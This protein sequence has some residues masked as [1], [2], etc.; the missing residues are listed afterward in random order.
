MYEYKP[1][2][3]KNTIRVLDLRQ[4]RDYGSLHGELR[5]VRLSPENALQPMD[6]DAPADNKPPRY[7]ALSYVWGEPTFSRSLDC[8][9]GKISLTSNLETALTALS[10][11]DR[12]RAIWVDAICIDQRN[13]AERGHQV[14]LMGQIFANAERVLIWLGPD[15]GGIARDT[16]KAIRSLARRPIRASDAQDLERV[17][18]EVT[19]LEW[20]YRLWVVQELVLAQEA[21]VLWGQEQLDFSWIQFVLLQSQAAVVM[22]FKWIAFKNQFSQFDILDALDWFRPLRCAD[23]RDRVYAI[24]G[25]PYGRG[26]ALTARVGDI[27]PDYA[28]SVEQLFYEIACICVECGQIATLLSQVHHT[29]DFGQ[30][31][32]LQ[33]PSW[34]PD[35]T[36]P[37]QHY[38]PRQKLCKDVTRW[39]RAQ[40][41]IYQSSRSLTLTGVLVDTVDC[42]TDESLDPTPS[43]SAIRQVS[44]FWKANV[45]PLKS[46]LEH[47]DYAEYEKS[48]LRA[49]AVGSSDSV[50]WEAFGAAFFNRN[51]SDIDLRSE[52]QSIRYAQQMV[53]SLQRSMSVVTNIQQD[54]DEVI[55]D[56]IDA[57]F[58]IHRFWADR[59]IF[60]TAS[61]FLGLGPATMRSGDYVI[62]LAGVNNPAILRQD[63]QA[64]R[65]IGN[66]HVPDIKYH[67]ALSSMHDRE[68][69]I[70]TFT[71][72]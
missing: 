66:S 5:N 30:V 70:Q 46:M 28:K 9:T 20:F 33:L 41:V 64:Y 16:F 11:H 44:E 23:D 12:R 69:R 52:W 42:T 17:I 39:L 36:C 32:T 62:V 1:L 49:L 45:L 63:G 38:T 54:H 56:E 35:W 22:D 37:T 53:Q 47:P 2:D 4:S 34:V 10:Y 72:R 3:D 71:I 25:L 6:S 26:R 18:R 48:F 24:L 27:E 40:P 31:G 59:R 21:S 58:G 7:E 61:G 15:P 55:D 50:E 14:K 68:L 19:S 51:Q 29:S 65:F 43:L 57:T 8:A 60:K 13:V 67:D